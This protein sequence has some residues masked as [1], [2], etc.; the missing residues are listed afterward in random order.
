MGVRRV[1]IRTGVV[2]ATEGGA[3]PRMLL[4]FRLFAGGPYGSGRQWFPWI[5]WTDEVRAIHYLIDDAAATGTFNLNAPQPLPNRQFASVLGQVMRRPSWLP[6]PA[7]AFRLIFGEMATL[8][9]DG[10]HQVPKRLV[11]SGFAFQYPTAE[12]TLRNLLA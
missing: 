2:L 12:A 4:P 3:F 7:V 8:L 1:V 10:Q 5:H 11:Q 9:L 6:V